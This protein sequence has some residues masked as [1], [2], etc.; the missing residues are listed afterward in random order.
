M[1]ESLLT[2][3]TFKIDEPLSWKKIQPREQ[4]ENFR[5]RTQTRIGVSCPSRSSKPLA[6]A[7]ADIC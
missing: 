1:E 6:N 3:E 2:R 5:K 4:A 7:A